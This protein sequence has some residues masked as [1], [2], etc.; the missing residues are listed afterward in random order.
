MR[1]AA[2]LAVGNGRL[3]AGVNDVGFNG[4]GRF[5]GH[6]AGSF[7]QLGGVRND[8][9][10]L[11]GGNNDTDDFP[12]LPSSNPLG[13][14]HDTTS[15]N[16]LGMLGNNSLFLKDTLGGSDIGLTPGLSSSIPGSSPP[17]F[18]PSNN[19]LQIPPAIGIGSSLLGGQAAG[20]PGR[21]QI[22]TGHPSS[23]YPSSG[24]PGLDNGNISS[25]SNLSGVTGNSNLTSSQLNAPGVS[26]LLG[27]LGTSITATAAP[28]PGLSKESRY[29]MAG[30]LETIRSTDKVSDCYNSRPCLSSLFY[31]GSTSINIRNRS[32]NIWIKLEFR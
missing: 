1:S 17:F 7:N 29:A 22:P 12:A 26:S 27:G 2:D 5:G 16:H 23:L 4:L 10:F 20:G 6:S 14:K 11:G 19:T 31:V 3:S 32:N 30:L 18:S 21:G 15:S 24:L 13:T 9:D 25:N 8:D 28:S